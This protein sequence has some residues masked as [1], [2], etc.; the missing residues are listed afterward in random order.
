MENTNSLC[1]ETSR[2][3]LLKLQI[4]VEVGTRLSKYYKLVQKMRK[5]LRKSFALILKKMNL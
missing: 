3:K 4:L 2:E 1:H 5:S